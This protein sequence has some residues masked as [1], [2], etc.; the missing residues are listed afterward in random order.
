MVAGSFQGTGV[1]IHLHVLQGGCH[2]AAGQ[3]VVDA[4]PLFALEHRTAIVK[5]S[6]KRAF[7]MDLAQAVGQA[8]I[9]QIFEPLSFD[10]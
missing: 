3:D 6:I 9:Q 1:V 2:C 4:Q 10:G 7:G 8:Q 5:P